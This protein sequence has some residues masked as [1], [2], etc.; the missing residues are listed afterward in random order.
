VSAILKGLN[1]N[2]CILREQDEYGA[3]YTV[4]MKVRINSREAI[5]VTG[6]IIRT[7]EDSLG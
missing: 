7:G 2:D 1:E 3:R 5:V 4:E 6:W